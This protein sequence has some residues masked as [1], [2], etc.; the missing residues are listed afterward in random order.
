M[1]SH[2]SVWA[3]G[4]STT[5]SPSP[6]LE[7]ERDSHH[8]THFRTTFRCRRICGRIK[9]E[10]VGLTISLQSPSSLCQPTE[11]WAEVL[12]TAPVT[13]LVYSKPCA[14]S[15][16]HILSLIPTMAQKG[17][18]LWSHFVQQ[19]SRGSKLHTQGHRPCKRQSQDRSEPGP[20][21]LQTLT[22]RWFSLFL[23]FISTL[24]PS[25]WPY[26]EESNS[27]LNNSTLIPESSTVGTGDKG[28][29]FMMHK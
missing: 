21:C 13:E 9:P 16:V 26:T 7:R 25:D 20:I 3:G 1:W 19:A 2:Y 22:C 29:L 10:A 11:R 6:F 27:S 8:L 12:K 28:K 14:M 17:W 23:I 15:F 18:C 5:I 4:C 24:T